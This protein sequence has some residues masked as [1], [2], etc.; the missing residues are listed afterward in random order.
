M[1][2]LFGAYNLVAPVIS[3]RELCVAS[4]FVSEL[5]DGERVFEL[6]TSL[7]GVS[8]GEVDRGVKVRC[9]TIYNAQVT[10]EAPLTLIFQALARVFSPL[11]VPDGS[12]R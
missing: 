10:R 9:V 5:S 7:A 4:S 12:A 2:F 3:E 11:T 6:C 8:L 1:E